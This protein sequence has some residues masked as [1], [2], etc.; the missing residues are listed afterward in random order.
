MKKFLLIMLAVCC[1]ATTA[2]A[3]SKKTVKQS[4]PFLSEYTT[5]YKIPP[6]GKIKI[7]DYMPALQAGI[8]QHNKEI[9]AIIANPEA[10]NFDNTV[11]ALDNSGEIFNK[12]TY[13]FYA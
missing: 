12:V 13:V 1:I 11:L 10:P 8:E 7:A 4:N 5:K 2:S 3:A 9:E 6:F